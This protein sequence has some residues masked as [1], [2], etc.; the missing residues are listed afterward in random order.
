M[1]D[2]QNMELQEEAVTYLV[3]IFN[4]THTCGS[5]SP[6]STQLILEST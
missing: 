2:S 4:Q 5:M 1:I 6:M 3:Y